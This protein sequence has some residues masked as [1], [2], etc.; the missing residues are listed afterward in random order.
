MKLPTPNPKECSGIHPP[1]S[2]APRHAPVVRGEKKP[3]RSEC[4]F[5]RV[6]RMGQ[7][8]SRVAVRGMGRSCRVAVIP[9]ASLRRGL[10]SSLTAF[11]R[12]T[13]SQIDNNT[14]SLKEWQECGTFSFLGRREAGLSR[15]PSLLFWCPPSPPGAG[16]EFRNP[17]PRVEGTSYRDECVWSATA[18]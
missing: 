18:L 17:V 11:Q 8:C 14:W 4:C 10:L 16:S 5:S 9:I 3:W 1:L 2:S 13:Q 6:L 12:W 7:G 15:K